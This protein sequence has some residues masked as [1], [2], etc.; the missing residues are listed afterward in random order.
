MRFSQRHGYK[1]VKSIVQREDVDDDLRV[2]MW[3]VLDLRI[4]SKG[5]NS[6]LTSRPVEYS[7]TQ[8][9]WKDFF[10]EPLDEIPAEWR[11]AYAE[12][13]SRYFN[14]SWDEV[15]DFVEFVVQVRGAVRGKEIAQ[16]LNV[17]LERERSAYRFVELSVVEIT[18]PEEIASIEDALASTASIPGVAT[19]LR[20]AID[21]LSDRDSP[22]YRNSIK[23]SISAVEA[24]T[25]RVA[26]TNG[27]T[28]GAALK[29]MNVNLHP[30]LDGAFSKLYGYTSDADGIRHAL[31]DEPNLE[32]EDAKFMLVACSAVVNYLLA[33]AGRAG[34]AV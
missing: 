3:N 12:I 32:F 24:M 9:L 21:L 18:S 1:P 11:K 22:D 4:W 19:H 15:L 23:E 13:R 33:K 2:G 16:D 34:V 30:A 10:K 31:M 28:L 6:W 8:A 17:V 20:S 5:D 14:C 26:G 29:Q 7:V 27:K 25:N